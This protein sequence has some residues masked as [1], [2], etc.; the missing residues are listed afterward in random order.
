MTCTASIPIPDCKN[1]DSREQISN[2]I[3]KKLEDEF[4]EIFKALNYVKVMY[5]ESL[6][7]SGIYASFDKHGNYHTY[8]LKNAYSHKLVMIVAD[9]NN[10]LS[11]KKSI[12]YTFN[13]IKR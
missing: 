3:R 1:M 10:F 6:S 13:K 11:G 4:P 8:Q 7:F 12:T 2:R 9:T 5:F